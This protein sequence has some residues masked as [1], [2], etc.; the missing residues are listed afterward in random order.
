MEK[1]IHTH[2]HMPITHM[3]YN[4]DTLVNNR[5]MNITHV[6]RVRYLLDKKM[7]YIGGTTL[8]SQKATT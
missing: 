6:F 7:E 3:L 8:L 4:V 2:M 1:Y 5:E